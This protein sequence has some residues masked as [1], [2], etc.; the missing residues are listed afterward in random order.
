MLNNIK[1]E[2]EIITEPN[3]IALAQ[4]NNVHLYRANI[5]GEKIDIE[6]LL[7]VQEFISY[8]QERKLDVFYNYCYLKDSAF[9]INGDVVMSAHNEICDLS[10]KLCIS[11]DFSW[12][13]DRELYP[14]AFEEENV[15]DLFSDFERKLKSKIM[16]YNKSVNI[17]N[18]RKIFAL[19][20]TVVCNG[21]NIGC[22]FRSN[23]KLIPL[24]TG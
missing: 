23:G 24:E 14:D 11:D 8:A 15:D 12:Y 17:E 7:S 16:E 2:I 5:N 1:K 13:I 10:E 9:L 22:I 21:K 20:C 3:L 6:M 4:Q 19:Y 18:E